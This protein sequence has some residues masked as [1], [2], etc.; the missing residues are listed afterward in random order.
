MQGKSHPVAIVVSVVVLIAF[1]VLWWWAIGVGI[2]EGQQKCDRMWAM[3]QTSA[4][5]IFVASECE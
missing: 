2:R 1:A 4:D 5:S 3:A